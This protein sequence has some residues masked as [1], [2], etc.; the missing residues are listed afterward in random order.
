M[1]KFTVGFSSEVTKDL[2]KKIIDS[3]KIKNIFFKQININKNKKE[4]L[5]NLVELDI[6]ITKYYNIPNEFFL[7]KNKLKFLQLTTSDYSFLDLNKFNRYAIKVANNGGANSVSVA[8]HIFLLMLSVNRNFIKQFITKKKKWN[9]LKSK[10]I[11]LFGKKIGIL[12]MGNAG[13]ELAKRCVSFGMIVSYFDTSRLSINFEKKLRIKFT[14]VKEIFKTS[15]IIS[16]NMSLNKKSENLINLK[17]LSSMKKN[18]LI[19]NTSRGKILKEK[20]LY[21][22]LKRKKISAAIDVYEKEPLPFNSKLRN[23]ENIIMTPHCGPSRETVDKL[24]NNIASNIQSVYLRKNTKR[25]KGI[26][27]KLL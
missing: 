19:I 7:L 21:K 17:L 22:I 3:I 10:N 5:K 9:N 26:I 20:N 15:D 6:F 16:L 12:G 27:W 25:L 18:S 23:L 1:E 4:L 2:K 11:E 24:S 14:R 8:E 13:L